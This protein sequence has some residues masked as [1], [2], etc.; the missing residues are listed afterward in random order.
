MHAL[1]IHLFGK[2]GAYRNSQ[3]VRGLDATKVQELLC[4]L[5]IKRGHPNP[6]EVL[7]GVLWG[8]SSAE[9]S[10]KYLRQALWHLQTAFGEAGTDGDEGIFLVEHD[11][12]RLNVQPSL[13]V[14]VEAF[15]QACVRVQGVRGRDFDQEAAESLHAAVELYTGDLLE[16]VYHD[17]CLVER[18]RLQNLYLSTLSKLLSYCLA[19]R[20]LERGLHY[21]ALARPRSG[22]TVAASRR[23]KKSSASG[24]TSTRRRCWSR[25]APTSSLSPAEVRMREARRTTRPRETFSPAC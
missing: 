14:D 2:F 8:E 23:S 7:A 15:E 13:W 12:V 19:S 20:C 16:G 21:G 3:A 9:K 10:R 6:R 4:Y 11:W 17:W 25:C 18:E 24:P 5:L 1:R 22:S